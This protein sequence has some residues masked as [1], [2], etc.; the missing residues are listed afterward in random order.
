M[1]QF[2]H[3]TVREFLL[4]ENGLTL[5]FRALATNVTSISHRI[6]WVAYLQCISINDMPKEYE[7]YCKASRKTNAHLNIFRSKMHLKLPFLDYAILYLFDH[8]KQ[9]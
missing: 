2:I 5:I 1:V 8:T 9:A 4:K 6:L 7:H 3:E